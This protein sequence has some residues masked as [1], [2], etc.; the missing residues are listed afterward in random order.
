MSSLTEF[1]LRA[2]VHWVTLTKSA[3]KWI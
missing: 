3:Y 1:E 2:I